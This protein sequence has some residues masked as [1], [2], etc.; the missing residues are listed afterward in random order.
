MMAAAALW[1]RDCF[2]LG[3]RNGRRFVEVIHH[4]RHGIVSKN[5]SE[6]GSEEAVGVELRAR[7][8][9]V[10]IVRG[11]Q[12]YWEATVHHAGV[13]SEAGVLGQA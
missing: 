13:V 2:H 8:G 7:D 6:V 4:C 9:K 3:Y 5:A 10:S 11:G 1:V 12:A